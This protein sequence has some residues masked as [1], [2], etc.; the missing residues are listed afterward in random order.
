MKTRVVVADDQA[1]FR[2]A[3]RSVLAA[4]DGFTLVGEAASGE[5]AIALVEALRPD[6]VLMDVRMGGMGGVRAARAIAAG[7]PETMTILVSTSQLRELP[8]DAATCGA[9]AFLHKSSLDGRTLHELWNGRA[10]SRFPT[11]TGSPP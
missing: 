8:R 11:G 3:T 9:A 1:P 5:E 6:L 4:T 2:S 7:R 10:T